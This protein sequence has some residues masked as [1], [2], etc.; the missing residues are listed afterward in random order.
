MPD[1]LLDYNYLTVA[2]WA[3]LIPIWALAGLLGIISLFQSVYYECL[4]ISS[5]Y[6]SYHDPRIK[7]SCSKCTYCSMLMFVLPSTLVLLIYHVIVF[8]DV[9]LLYTCEVDFHSSQ[10]DAAW[11]KI[12]H[13][14]ECC[15]QHNYTDW[16]GQIPGSCCKN[17]CNGCNESNAFQKGCLPFIKKIFTDALRSETIPLQF[18]FVMSII[19]IILMFRH[20]LKF[21]FP[22]CFSRQQGNYYDDPREDDIEAVSV[23]EHVENE[24][25]ENDEEDEDDEQLLEDFTQNVDNSDTVFCYR[26][27]L[28]G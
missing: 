28:Y 14:F 8:W 15:G 9:S 23:E 4:T 20:M 27:P 16:G 5:N 12:Q 25:D 7:Q 3:L 10:F 1:D 19:F 21:V 24:E 13:T 22:K 11:D 17:Y 6:V 26:C 2:A 18:L